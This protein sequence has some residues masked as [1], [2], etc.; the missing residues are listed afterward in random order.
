MIIER[1]ELQVAEGKEEAFATILGDARKILS[2]ADGCR[3][4]AAARGV[5]NPSKFLLLLEWDS[6][7]HHVAFTG[8]NYNLCLLI[9]KATLGVYDCS[10]KPLVHEVCVGV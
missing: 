10:S 4:V 1:V 9:A 7:G 8:L 6:V 3:S 2:S 5:E